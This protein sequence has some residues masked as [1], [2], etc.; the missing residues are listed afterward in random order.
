MQN[1]SRNTILF[2]VIAM[3]ILIGYQF[4]VL[5]PN[6]KKRQAE[7]KAKQAEVSQTVEPGKA[8]TAAPARPASLSRDAAKAA[9]PR[10][11]IETTA[12]TD[13]KPTKVLSGSIN[14]RG[15][16][17]DDLYL[18]RY[19]VTVDRNSARVDL[20]RPEG[21]A[22]AWFAEFG[23][24]ADNVPGLPNHETVWTAAPGQR[25]TQSTPVV[26]TYTS[27]QGLLFTR[28]IAVDDHYMFT[29]TDKVTNTGGGAVSLSPF[30]AVRRQGLP[31]EAGKGQNVHEG[32]VGIL[33]KEGETEK[34]QLRLLKYNPWK[35][36]DEPQRFASTG[37]WLGITDKYWLAA[38][39]PDQS[40]LIQAEYRAR[41]SRGIDIYE[42]S[43]VGPAHQIAPG[44][45]VTETTRLFAGAKRVEQLRAYQK[46]L[47]IPRFENA[48]DWGVLWFLTQPIFYALEFFFGFVKNF[49]VA[50]L[51]V[52]LCVRVLLFPLANKSY[53]SMSR[54]KK[55]T[56]PMQAIKEKYKD[57]PAKM[58][59][60]T[61]AL[62]QR[63]KVNPLAGC[64]PLL[65]QIPVFLA[66]FKV[67]SVTIEMRHA[68][69]F[70]FIK[71][72][73]ARDPTNMWN[74]FGLLP[75]DPGSVPVIGF[76]LAGALGLGVMAILYGFTM[77]LTTAMN[78]PAPDPM[79]QRIFQLMPILFTFIMAPFAVGL[80]LYWTFSNIL[81]IFQQYIIMHR[82]KVDNP[83][84]DFLA[85]IG[86]GKAVG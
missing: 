18:N 50:I 16:R 37:G 15:G 7:L 36:K 59:Q 9:T 12:N 8:P 86:G 5:E 70:G 81:S 85:R 42:T 47:G 73:S 26:L 56:E 63:E 30:A 61:M 25:L 65:L 49:G 79:Q 57:D 3:V 23:W 71:D 34:K 84:D 31:P 74:L 19:G 10:V 27:P 52:T 29:I 75:Y 4:F 44:A 43:Y 14:L 66:F 54:M 38:L 22:N 53:E 78:P 58:Q 69:F 33:G 55:L 1:D 67:L 82:L 64:L 51:L 68:P 48:V 24:V 45:S 83:I 32:A 62:Y 77:W 40:E 39:I 76:L 35:K 60:E 72:L 20:L 6:A 41:S 46:E 80:I 28:T 2:I 11:P 21:T 17:I 13:G